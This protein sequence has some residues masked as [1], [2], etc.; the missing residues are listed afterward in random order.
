M[1]DNPKSDTKTMAP[2]GGQTASAEARV[3]SPNTRFQSMARRPGGM[4]R[5]KAIE[6]AQAAIEEVKV[7]FDDWLDAEL[8]ALCELIERVRL[9]EAGPGWVESAQFHCNQLRDVGGTVGFE[10]L[11]FVARTLCTIFDGIHAGAECNMESITCHLDALQLIRQ[12]QYRSLRP[13]QLPELSTGLFRV[14][15]S[16]SIVPASDPARDK[17]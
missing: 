8:R 16:V 12:P 7:G 13:D 17:K 6:N 11:T 15:E 9:G 3:F 5:D 1:A 10:L 2:P 4:R 14:A